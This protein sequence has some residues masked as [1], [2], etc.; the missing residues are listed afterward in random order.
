[1]RIKFLYGKQICSR[2]AL[3]GA[4]FG[5]LQAE[6]VPIAIVGGGSVGVTVDPYAAQIM[7]DG[8]VKDVGPLVASNTFI[9]SVYMNEFGVSLIGGYDFVFGVDAPFAAFIDVQGNVVTL[10][11]LPGGSGSIQDVVINNQGVGLIGGKKVTADA[12]AA[13]VSSQ[14]FSVTEVPGLPS[15]TVIYSVDLNKDGSGLIGGGDGGGTQPFYAAFVEPDLSVTPITGL[16]GTNGNI[17]SVALND[18]KAA[19]LGGFKLGHGDAYLVTVAAGSTVAQSIPLPITGNGTIDSVAINNAGNGVAGGYSLGVP[20]AMLVT[21]FGGF[22]P[23]T[24][25]PTPAQ[26][27]RVAINEAGTSIIGGYQGPTLPGLAAFI[28]PGSADADL[29]TGLKTGAYIY[30]VD[31]SPSGVALIGGL[32]AN[33]NTAFIYLVAPDKSLTELQANLGAGTSLIASMSI[34]DIVETESIAPKATVS[35]LGAIYTQFGLISALEAHLTR[36]AHHGRSKKSFKETALLVDA[37]NPAENGGKIA[38]QNQ[39]QEKENRFDLWI[40]P[41]ATFIF[42]DQNGQNPSCSNQMGGGLLG[43]DYQFSHFLVGGGLAYAYNAIEYGGNLG[44]GNI[45]EELGVLYATYERKNLWINGALWS[46]IY[47]LTNKRLTLG[48]IPSNAFTKGWMLSPHGELAVPFAVK[49]DERIIVEPF[50]M[51]DWVNNWQDGF[52]ETGAAGLNIVMQKQYTSLLRSEI[53]SRFYQ[54]VGTR[55]G[56]LGFEE[57]LSYV[58]QLPFNFGVVTTNFVASPSTFSI[59]I[60][61]NQVQNLGAAEFHMTYTAENKKMP[62]V[63]LDF[64]G[65]WGVS[66]QSYFVGVELG[67]NF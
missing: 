43:L 5:Q 9:Q 53:G 39:K 33:D 63:S 37:E 65:E 8:T 61:S 7:L 27:N 52:T 31:I 16:L 6:N 48:Y 47:Q 55:W 4:M 58:N 54:T 60:G 21:E 46:G 56:A 3:L 57:K 41:F 12:Y 19:V 17:Q 32:N 11:G 36:D 14:D 59:A 13:Y 24:G 1:M 15:N 66:Y 20:V 62:Y 50:V 64:Q 28:A 18:H 22:T 25:L 30:A 2:I 34:R 29:I 23:I 67:R 26:I 45:Q 10:S 42:Q 35:G 44:H 40:A 51:M 38:R 49:D